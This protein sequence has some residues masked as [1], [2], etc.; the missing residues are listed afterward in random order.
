LKWSRVG[1]PGS[2]LSRVRRRERRVEKRE[3][4][5]VKTVKNIFGGG[6][7]VRLDLACGRCEDGG[8][9]VKRKWPD[10]RQSW[11]CHF[12][13]REVEAI[14]RRGSWNEDS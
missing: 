11:G 8:R 9:I 3:A 10:G 14:K 4:I 13:G 6:Y 7:V 12:C 1:S 5:T 2:G